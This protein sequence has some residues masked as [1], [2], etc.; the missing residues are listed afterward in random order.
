MATPYNVSHIPSPPP[1]LVP[2]R[3]LPNWLSSRIPNPIRWFSNSNHHSNQVANDELVEP[4]DRLRRLINNPK[5]PA[6][7][8]SAAFARA[9]DITFRLEPEPDAEYESQSNSESEPELVAETA[10]FGRADAPHDGLHDIRNTRKSDFTQSAIGR[11]LA[12]HKRLND[13]ARRR[14]E[15]WESGTRWQCLKTHCG[16]STEV[17]IDDFTGEEIKPEMCGKEGCR[18]KRLERIEGVSHIF[19]FPPFLCGVFD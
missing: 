14:Y 1:E 17:D 16:W 12:E 3:W 2:R 11:W 9:M 19:F 7:D 18:G 10:T 4:S 8:P 5:H 6:H 15:L 13:I